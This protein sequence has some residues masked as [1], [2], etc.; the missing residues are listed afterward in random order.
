MHNQEMIILVV[1][2]LVAIFILYQ[3]NSPEGFTAKDQLHANET[4]KLN[5][6]TKEELIAELAMLKVVAKAAE[7]GL[8]GDAVDHSK[9]VTKTEYNSNPSTCTVAVAEDRD[10]YTSKCNASTAPKVDMSKYTLKSSIPLEKVCPAPVQTDLSQYVLKSTIPPKQACGDCICPKVKVSAGLCKKCDP[11]PACPV[12]EPCPIM[13]CPA[14]KACPVVKEKK[15]DEIRYI[16]TPTIITKTIH[17]DHLGKVVSTTLGEATTPTQK[18]APSGVPT[19]T[20]LVGSTSLNKGLDQKGDTVHT[21]YDMQIPPP[22][23][24]KIASAVS[25]PQVVRSYDV[26][27]KASTCNNQPDLNHK[28]KNAPRSIYGLD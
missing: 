23:A 2:L 21:E 10:K 5:N 18:P 20:L 8:S 26:R 27:H 9:Y 24:T 3:R 7:L 19:P 14:P 22:V 25:N 15:C 4:A 12:P 16:K 28:F 17:L 6:K 11:C 13:N 1:L